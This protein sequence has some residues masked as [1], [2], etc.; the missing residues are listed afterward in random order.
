MPKPSLQQY[1]DLQDQINKLNRKLTTANDTIKRQIEERLEREQKFL[2]YQSIYRT[3]VDA[4][5]D[6][7][8]FIEEVK[9]VTEAKEAKDALRAAKESAEAA[10]AAK[11]QFL[12][13]MSH[14]IRTPLNGVIGVLNLLLSTNPDSEQ[15]SL[16]QTGKRSADNL[17]TVINDILDFS[18]TEAGELDLEIIDFDLHDAIEEAMELPAMRAHEQGVA[19]AY[20]IEPDVPSLLKGDPGRLRQILLNLSNNALKFTSHGEV[21][22]QVILE[23]DSSD[24]A[25]IRF[26]IIDTG[27][28]IA[29]DKQQ[30]I[31][32]AFKQTDASTTRLYGGTGLGL[33][34]CKRLSELMGGEIGVISQLGQG[35]TFWVIIPFKKQP[36]AKEIAS[37]APP[38]IK[39]KRFLLVDDNQNNLKILS[40]YIEGW[41]CSCDVAH[42][43]K[44]ALTLL[45]A[46]AKVGAPFDA[47][48]IDML[49]PTMD[50]V[51]LGVKIKN[52]PRLQEIPMIMLTSMGL[53]GDASKMKA[54]GFAAYL[55]KPVKRS[56]LRNC[57]IKV[58]TNAHTE[59][60]AHPKVHPMVTKY[61]ITEPAKNGNRI[62]IVEDNAINQ[63]I[64]VQMIK[65]F[66]FRTTIAGNGKEALQ[67]LASA[68]FDMVLMDVEMPVM[69]GLEATMRIRDI[70]S[71]V[72][73][74]DIP[75]VAMTACA[76]EGDK[77]RC[78][79]VGMNDYISKPVQPRELMDTILKYI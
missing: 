32:Q 36:H 58:L 27:I 61:T 77:Q 4:Q 19:F 6:P 54:I 9:N 74:H 46:L 60:S 43:G 51:E 30:L 5:A 65:N 67:V 73:D 23:D 3:L 21:I 38:D 20:T 29:E 15:I 33:S 10:N 11:S 39:D 57:I 78:L 12:A 64:A 52:D 1:R 55:T 35:S 42:S 62:L 34:I 53:R 68:H 44:M 66:G 49:M 63:K 48:I 14:E 18:K 40:S 28:G 76:M 22:I 70:N 31:F 72:R 2:E 25:A 8:G 17:H 56:Q 69:N 71:G 59:Q 45:N 79:D 13:N 50:G 41:G 7:D 26:E 75:V 47:V 16:I 24:T 37:S